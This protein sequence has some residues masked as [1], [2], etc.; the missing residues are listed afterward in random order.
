MISLFADDDLLEHIV[1][2]G[3]NV[4]ALLYDMAN[5]TSMDV[6][7]SLAGDFPWEIKETEER[8]V[9][10]FGRVFGS[11][12]LE[13]FDTK[14]VPKPRFRKEGADRRFGGYEFAFKVIEKE[15][16][17]KYAG[18]A[19]RKSAE[20][21]VV[22]PAQERTFTV[23]FSVYEHIVKQEFNV[24]GYRIQAYSLDLIAVE[25]LRAICQQFPGYLGRKGRSSRSR[26]FF[27][28]YHLV[29]E[30]RV[31]FLDRETLSLVRPVFEA[32]AVPLDYLARLD[33][34]FDLHAQ[35]FDGLKAT[36]P[37]SVE[38]KSFE[39]YFEYVKKISSAVYRE[40]TQSSSAG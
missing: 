1:L 13:V 11:E 15:Q 30:G 19:E 27:D 40:L 7:A 32:K 35:S 4:L 14:L 33:E 29:E 18:R 36:V 16:S 12:G 26:D 39:F 9:A 3:G 22:G 23:D 24:K 25:K 34:V 6:D 17:G 2:K 38:M 10:A 5:R 28:I 8:L 31:N 37:A 20:A 21:T